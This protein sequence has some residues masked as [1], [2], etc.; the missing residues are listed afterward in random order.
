[1]E[2]DT[3]F[4]NQMSEHPDTLSIPVSVRPQAHETETADEAATTRI[5][6]DSNPNN[7]NSA[8]VNDKS[9]RRD[10]TRHKDVTPLA[11]ETNEQQRVPDLSK[12]RQTNENAPNEDEIIIEN[13]KE[14]L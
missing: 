14:S 4:G 10:A 5:R 7:S 11:N 8:D 6:V 12:Q 13:T 1:M 3:S 9:V 2:T